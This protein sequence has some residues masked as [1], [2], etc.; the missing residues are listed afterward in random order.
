V[1]V[2]GERQDSS[3][4]GAVVASTQASRSTG[5]RTPRTKGPRI[6]RGLAFGGW[7]GGSR[8]RR[9]SS[10]T[11]RRCSP[12]AKRRS[13]TSIPVSRSSPVQGERPVRPRIRSAIAT[14]NRSQNSGPDRIH[15]PPA[16]ASEMSKVPSGII[17]SSPPCF[18]WAFGKSHLGS[19]GPR[20][21]SGIPLGAA[22][23][24]TTAARLRRP[25]RPN[26]RVP[27]RHSARARRADA[28][29]R[30]RRVC[31]GDPL[32]RPGFESMPSSRAEPLRRPR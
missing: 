28:A 15:H 1:H 27:R 18:Q 31:G 30:R 32:G 8:R 22:S 9:F 23:I 25:W 13:S 17:G 6:V 12:S 4:G 11:E 20:H 3:I 7:V 2:Q 21:L 29:R 5:L 19:G 16:K 24:P 10:S 14:M 26:G